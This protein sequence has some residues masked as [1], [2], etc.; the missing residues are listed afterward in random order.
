LGLSFYTAVED[1]R[2]TATE[3]RLPGSNKKLLWATIL[4]QV[5][6]SNACDGSLAALL[7][8]IIRDYLQ[9]PSDGWKPT[10]TAATPTS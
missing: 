10:P 2:E 6:Q 5:A 9:K 4:A 7:L 3:Y 1:I 8:G